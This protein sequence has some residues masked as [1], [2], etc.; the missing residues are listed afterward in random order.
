MTAINLLGVHGVPLMIL[1]VKD[2]SNPGNNTIVLEDKD[3]SA[4]L[5][6]L[7]ASKAKESN[8]CSTEKI[9][10]NSSN[11]SAES[12]MV[13]KAIARRIVEV[14]MRSKPELKNITNINAV[15]ENAV[16]L[17]AETIKN[18][19]PDGTTLKDLFGT[20]QKWNLWLNCTFPHLAPI[21][22]RPFG[23]SAVL[24]ASVE[25]KI[26]VKEVSGAIN[27]AL[28]GSTIKAITPPPPPPP[29]AKTFK[30]TGLEVADE[31]KEGDTVSMRV[32]GQHFPPGAKISVS[33]EGNVRV[34]TGPQTVPQTTPGQRPVSG[35]TF[36]VKIGKKDAQSGTA[37]T[38][39][40]FKDGQEIKPPFSWTLTITPRADRPPRPPR[41]PGD[42]PPPPPRPRAGVCNGKV[43]AEVVNTCNAKC[44]P[45]QEPAA[46]A[47]CIAKFK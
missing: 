23:K 12:E 43:D 32:K 47:K 34:I 33:V 5:D 37:R 21:G 30:I 14:A 2:E 45:I 29:V 38:V 46:Q 9:Y 40:I 3:L 4:I 20:W 17:L 27:T 13:R 16:N 39:R 28:Q 22:P 18:K 15:K 25:L 44:G 1:G 35:F 26:T 11:N 41:E 7:E 42:N 24:P 19:Y 8:R 31:A 6:D 36:A 10:I